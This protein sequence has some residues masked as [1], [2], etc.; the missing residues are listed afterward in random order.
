LRV[1]HGRRLLGPDAGPEFDR[2][3][4]FF[5]GRGLFDAPKRIQT[6]VIVHVTQTRPLISPGYDHVTDEAEVRARMIKYYLGEWGE[7]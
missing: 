6:I 1:S 4:E 5:A 7:T 2:H 3:V